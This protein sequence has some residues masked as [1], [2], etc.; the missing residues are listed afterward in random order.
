MTLT[1]AFLLFQAIVFG[2]FGVFSFLNPESTMEI[3]GAPSMSRMGL[4]E[5]RGIYGGVSIGAALLFLAGFFKANMQRPALYFILAYGGGYVLARFAA[6][7]LDGL[8]TSRMW[9][10]VGFEVISTLIAWM[11]IRRLD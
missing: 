3:L 10:F 7:P 9:V 11:L 2:A 8:P 5:M 6:M 1:R 4:Y